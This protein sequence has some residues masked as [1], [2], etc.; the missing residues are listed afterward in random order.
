MIGEAETLVAYSNCSCWGIS[1][2]QFLCLH[3]Q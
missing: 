1:V 2:Y 3:Q